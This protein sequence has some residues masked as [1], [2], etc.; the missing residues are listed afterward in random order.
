MRQI[1]L[2][3]FCLA[4]SLS[5]AQ[6]KNHTSYV[7]VNYF[8]GNIAL[9]NNEILHLIQGHP[10]GVILSWNKKTYGFE[11][12]DFWLNFVEQKLKFYQLQEVLFYYR[13]QQ[14]DSPSMSMA[15]NSSNR[16]K[17]MIQQI[18]YNHPKLYKRLI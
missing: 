11:D 7:D 15:L 3:V 6:D 16:K 12:W 13:R 9:H 4:F 8:Q 18:R 17:A 5:F 1:F 10:D 14:S 2:C